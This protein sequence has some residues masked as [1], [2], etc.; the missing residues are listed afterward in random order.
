[1]PATLEPAT[2][3]DA[4]ALAEL[5]NAVADD[6]TARHG[7]GP[8]SLHGTERG[9]LFAMRSSRV[10]VARDRGAI[11]A[12][13]RLATKRPWAIDVSFFTPVPKAL[14]LL[15]MAV[16]P[17]RQRR[18]LGRRCLTDAARLTRAH[19]ANAIRLDAFDADAGAGPFYARCGYTERGRVTY[20]DAPLIY[21][22]LLL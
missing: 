10:F 5:H 3:E 4:V 19:S 17:D 20:R 12:T 6:L 18:G 16:R 14:Y 15:G 13:L 21:Y 8:W 7:R 9:A 22:E 11:V 2:T 1:M